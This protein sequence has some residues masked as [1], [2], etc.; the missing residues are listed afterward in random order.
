MS[1]YVVGL[2]VLSQAAQP[3][4]VVQP[5]F[6]FAQK[7]DHVYKLPPGWTVCSPPEGRA[8][9][10]VRLDP[11]PDRFALDLA[12]P[13]RE[14]RAFTLA[15]EAAGRPCLIY[16]AWIAPTF[17]SSVSLRG[18]IL[19]V[20]GSALQ[21]ADW[22][23]LSNGT[24]VEFDPLDMQSNK[25][26]LYLS[27]PEGYDRTASLTA[28]PEDLVPLSGATFI[29]DGDVVNFRSVSRTSTEAA[30]PEIFVP[31]ADGKIVAPSGLRICEGNDAVRSIKVKSIKAI[32]V[33]DR[34]EDCTG[35]APRKADVWPPTLHKSDIVSVRFEMMMGDPKPW[36]RLHVTLGSD[37]AVEHRKTLA[38]CPTGVTGCWVSA[39]DDPWLDNCEGRRCTYDIDGIDS[40]GQATEPIEVRP[41]GLP[42]N[43][44]VYLDGKRFDPTTPP[45]W[46]SGTSVWVVPEAFQ[47]T[48][49]LGTVGAFQVEL[50]QQVALHLDDRDTLGC[51][52]GADRKRFCGRIWKTEGSAQIALLPAVSS[53]LNTKR[54]VKFEIPKSGRSFASSVV[55]DTVTR[56][57][58]EARL[59]S[60]CVYEMRQLTRAPGGH[61]QTDT[62]I[63]VASSESGCWPARLSPKAT[64]DSSAFV[65]GL[66]LHPVNLVAGLYR[67]RFSTNPDKLPAAPLSIEL[68]RPDNTKLDGSVL[69]IALS[70]A[71]QVS[72]PIGVRTQ[73]KP[74]RSAPFALDPIRPGPKGKLAAERDNILRLTNM[75]PASAWRV[76]TLHPDE[77]G[78]CQFDPKPTQSAL[79]RAEPGRPL[80]LDLE[81]QLCMRPR[82]PFA[83]KAAKLRVAGR[84]DARDVILRPELQS[85]VAKAGTLS[86]GFRDFELPQ[87]IEYRVPLDL[88]SQVFLDC[89]YRDDKR[90]DG[91]DSY[92]VPATPSGFAKCRLGLVIPSAAI[93]PGTHLRQQQVN[94]WL[95]R[96]IGPQVLVVYLRKKGASQSVKAGTVY[97]GYDFYNFD[98][99]RSRANAVEVIVPVRGWS[100]LMQG[101]VKR[102]EAYNVEVGYEEPDRYQ[103][104][105]ASRVTARTSKFIQK[106]RRASPLADALWPGGHGIRGSVGVLAATVYRVPAAPGGDTKS[107]EA[108]KPQ[109]ITIDG[110]LIAQFEVWDYRRNRPWLILNP[111]LLVGVLPLSNRDP[112]LDFRFI[113]GIGLRAP[114]GSKPESPVDVGLSL[115][116]MLELST[117][118][119]AAW[120]FGLQG[121]ISSPTIFD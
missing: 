69:K 42:P 7:P 28:T 60:D 13:V 112:E 114:F 26:S 84:A 75:R 78:R 83:A 81:N 17:A 49:V 101:L 89:P 68:R 51:T 106:M 86:L 12:E 19:K 118:G 15:V 14:P 109:E 95:L 96:S 121:N 32:R 20:T 24:P 9:T 6:V 99:V 65:S 76:S 64:A 63:S 56:M 72:L 34:G 46:K 35:T 73:T 33:V 94:D 119:G 40:L 54:I 102:A 25:E 45:K 100:P 43:K 62:L 66:D 22:S 74:I 52:I 61:Q 10:S 77:V 57:T 37:A 30:T 107:S 3:S 5:P 97:F 104:A 91:R 23:I 111:Q 82:H 47:T 98:E 92:A 39:A 4:P 105:P 115:T 55:A 1:F 88:A 36:L 21:F 117:Q 80:V 53:A 120:L 90:V 108:R 70:E 29:D 110:G 93:A 87:A 116:A 48:Q 113:T 85:L 38:L 27:V 41:R 44:T 79:T 59:R 31:R 11:S 8:S 18:N 67:L 16:Q 50:P 58:I 71:P 2:L 103:H